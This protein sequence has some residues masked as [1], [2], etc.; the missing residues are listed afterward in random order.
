MILS[1]QCADISGAMYGDLRRGLARVQIG[2]MRVLDFSSCD[3][4]NR[5]AFGAGSGWPVPVSDQLLS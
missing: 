3:F 2:V 4:G 1:T 5:S